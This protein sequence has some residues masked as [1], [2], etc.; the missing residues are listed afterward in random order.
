M[1]VKIRTAG[2]CFFGFFFLVLF[3]FFLLQFKVF[4]YF[5]NSVNVMLMK[6]LPIH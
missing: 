4:V 2:I 5:L 1:G 3:F 6:M